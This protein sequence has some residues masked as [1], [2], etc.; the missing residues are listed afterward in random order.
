MCIAFPGKI[1]SIN[2]NSAMVDF[3]GVKK[4]INISLTPR[5]KKGDYVI[6]HCG[7]AIQ[8]MEKQ[9]AKETLLVSM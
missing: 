2:K 6:V 5:L 1:I 3:D 4:E 8:K 9:E 7:F